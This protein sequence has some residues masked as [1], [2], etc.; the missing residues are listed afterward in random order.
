VN[1]LNSIW[2]VAFIS[3]TIFANAVYTVYMAD[4]GIRNLG[5]TGNT[6]SRIVEIVFSAIFVFELLV[7]L[8]VHQKYF[9]WNRDTRWNLLDLVLVTSSIA[10]QTSLLVATTSAPNTNMSFL[11]SLR[12]L[13]LTRIFRVLRVIRVVRE[14]RNILVSLVGSFISLFWCLLMLGLIIVCFS[15]VFVMVITEYL[16]NYADEIEPAVQ[17]G[18]IL[19]FGGVIKA[20]RTLYM[21]TTGGD[22]WSTYYDFLA[23]TGSATE[24]LFIFFISF[25][26]F[27]VFNVLTGIFVDNAMKV[28]RADRDIMVMEQRQKEFR[29]AQVLKAV[30]EEMDED[31]SGGISWQE[32]KAHLQDPKAAAHLAAI[33]LDV[34]D[35]RVFF[36]ILEL[37]AGKP[38]VDID[39]FVRGCMRMKGSATSIDMQTLAYEVRQIRK[40][41]EKFGEL[42]LCLQAETHGT[43]EALQRRS[44]E[45]VCSCV[46][47]FQ[48]MDTTPRSHCSANSCDG[49][50]P[51]FLNGATLHKASTLPDEDSQK[52]LSGPEHDF[53]CFRRADGLRPPE[54]ASPP[55]EDQQRQPP[56]KTPAKPSIKPVRGA[57]AAQLSKSST[58][59]PPLPQPSFSHRSKAAPTRQQPDQAVDTMDV[60]LEVGGLD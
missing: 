52:L 11:R 15:L 34:H 37:V 21:A 27:A 57:A 55:G 48:Q 28:S 9:F 1:L 38:E 26:N 22:D 3:L 33:G 53:A 31:K 46:E 39:I 18:L 17:E 5:T 23:E 58:S 4:Y 10:D 43:A 45:G 44:F 13:R 8:I 7:K 25:F 32:F 36:E 35:A 47:H 56:S 12:I 49:S 2:F 20:M 54:A 14:L 30:C 60:E 50:M 41:Q 59:F 51:D 19:Y 42:V 29:D 6:A 16:I 40:E 24:L